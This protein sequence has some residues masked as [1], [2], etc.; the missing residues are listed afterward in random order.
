MNNKKQTSTILSYPYYKEFEQYVID[1]FQLKIKYKE[2]FIGF[3]GYKYYLFWVKI[4]PDN[5]N[6]TIKIKESFSINNSS[7]VIELDFIKENDEC[8]KQYITNAYKTFIDF[9]K[10][11]DFEEIK[12]KKVKRN[13]SE[14]LKFNNKKVLS[15]IEEQLIIEA[16]DDMILNYQEQA[17]VL[18]ENIKFVVT[19]QSFDEDTEIF[20]KYFNEFYETNTTLNEIG[21]EYKLSRQSIS[22]ILKRILKKF[23]YKKFQEFLIPTI[24]SIN[25]FKDNEYLNFIYYGIILEYPTRFVKMI[26][27]I[28]YENSVI[29]Q[30]SSFFDEIIKCSKS[31]RKL[32]IKINNLNNSNFLYN[33][34]I[35][36]ANTITNFDLTSVSSSDFKYQYQIYVYEKLSRIN[37]IDKIYIN[38]NIYFYVSSISNHS[39]DFLIKTKYGEIILILISPTANMAVSFNR[40]RFNS[41]HNFCKENNF[42]YIIMN[43]YFKTIDD[44]KNIQIDNLIKNKLDFILD[45]NGLINWNDIKTL[46]ETH[47]IT[48]EIISSYVLNNKFEFSL[49]PYFIKK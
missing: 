41:L 1:N 33:Q 13:I 34:S 27:S 39:P 26:L 22:L 29:N 14:I 3:K 4:N 24:E 8:I 49:K 35:F 18:V 2:D 45:K 15:I 47:K 37:V 46:K 31:N 10:S 11:E 17:K 9:K 25:N 30:I 36:P 7:N 23:N 5:G 19:H 43:K 20:F 16:T 42:G 12:N 48:S 28:F 44:I 6:L 32:E 38:P 21:I 40:N